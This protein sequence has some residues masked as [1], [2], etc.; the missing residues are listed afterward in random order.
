MVKTILNNFLLKTLLALFVLATFGW[1]AWTQYQKAHTVTYVIPPGT[2]QQLAAGEEAVNFPNELILSIGD[3]IVIENQDSAVHVFGPF[4]ILP[5]TTLT[6]RFKTARVYKN[7]CT[8][9]QDQQMT[10]IVTP[11]SWNIF[12]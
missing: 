10:L 12:E 4:T 6:K 9:H 2:S 7:S 3:T 8:F 1:F 5:H 11:A